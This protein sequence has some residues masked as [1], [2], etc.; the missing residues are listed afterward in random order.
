[1][2]SVQ[3]VVP[4]ALLCFA[5][6]S[7]QM[8]YLGSAWEGFNTCPDHILSMSRTIGGP[9]KAENYWDGELDIKKWPFIRD[10]RVGLTLDNP[11]KIEFVS[12]LAQ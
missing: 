11:A 12:N 4:V 9:P 2:W 1:M 10:V 5:C 6:C 7:A 3:I 8:S